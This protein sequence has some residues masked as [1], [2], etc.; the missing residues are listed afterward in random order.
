MKPQSRQINFAYFKKYVLVFLAGSY[1]LCISK[2]A[3]SQMMSGIEEQLQEFFIAQPVYP[4]HKNEIQFTTKPTY[5][6]IQGAEITNFPFQ[7]EYGLTNRLQI[8]LELP[9]GSSHAITGERLRGMGNA[10]IGFLFNILKGT[11]PF[12]MSLA[13]EVGLP[14]EKRIKGFERRKVAWEP[15]LIVANQ[16]GRA[17]VHAS[18]G[19]ELVRG[20]SAFNYNLASVY[21][22]GAWR[23]HC[24]K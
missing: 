18:F 14:T 15:S 10:E 20:E 2:T 21:P 9:Y 1:S 23:W 13:M 24:T 17:Q 7:V 6:K 22:F 5:W 16:I 4:Q 3:T 11:N 19:A 8:E 12:A